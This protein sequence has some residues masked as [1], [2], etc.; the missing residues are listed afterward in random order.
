MTGVQTCALPI[1]NPRIKGAGENGKLFN[2]T[3]DKVRAHLDKITDGKYTP[4]DMRTWHATSMAKSEIDKMP[5]PRNDKEFKAARKEVAEKVAGH[6]GNTSTV[7]IN[8][9]ID[10]RVWDKWKQ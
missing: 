4:K 7:A 9:Y 6:L 5:K 8:S 10:P 3:D 1:L 2:T